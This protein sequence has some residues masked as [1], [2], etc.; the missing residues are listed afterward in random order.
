METG[1]SRLGMLQSGC[2]PQAA[3]TAHR[4]HFIRNC[5]KLLMGLCK[6][7]PTGGGEAATDS[8]ERQRECEMFDFGLDG[9]F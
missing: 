6:G 2:A 5:R 9:S 7:C 1:A 3:G 4:N 8:S